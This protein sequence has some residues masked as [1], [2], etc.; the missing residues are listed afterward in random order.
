MKRGGRASP[1]GEGE[2]VGLSMMGGGV[3]GGGGVIGPLGGL[4]GGILDESIPLTE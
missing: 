2:D 4:M 3:G 1:R